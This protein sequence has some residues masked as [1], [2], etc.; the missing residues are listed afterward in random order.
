MLT[1]RQKQILNIIV[2]WYIRSSTPVPS[3]VVASKMD[4]PVSSATIRNEMAE[5]DKAGYIMRPHT[6]AGGVPF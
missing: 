2:D 3:D 1:G 5:L 4:R 6:S